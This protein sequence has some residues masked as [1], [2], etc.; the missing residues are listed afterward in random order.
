MSRCPGCDHQ[1]I[2]LVYGL[3]LPEP[4]DEELPD[5]P[6]TRV[7]MGCEM[8]GPD[9]RPPLGAWCPGCE[10]P[11]G[12]DDSVLGWDQA[13]GRPTD[14][15]PDVGDPEE[16]ASQ[17]LDAFDDETEGLQRLAVLARWRGDRLLELEAVAWLSGWGLR[18]LVDVDT[19]TCME[20]VIEL[21]GELTEGQ[22]QEVMPGARLADWHAE[23]ARWQ[24]GIGEYDESLAWW[25]SAL[26]VLPAEATGDP[27]DEIRADAAQELYEAGATDEV[28]ALAEEIFPRVSQSGAT[29]IPAK[30]ADLA[31]RIHEERAN[32][33]D[34]LTW[35]LAM[36][37]CE[38]RESD[39]RSLLPHTADA[40]ESCA[41]R[42]SGESRTR[43][44][45]ELSR[46]ARQL[47]ED[48]ERH[49]QAR[50]RLERLSTGLAGEAPSASR[51]DPSNS[52][53]S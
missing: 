52:S 53:S 24:A 14:H 47:D 28:L 23:V 9:G 41:R 39:L 51:P 26:Q 50:A 4:R 11:F 8:P 43:A 22:Q 13:W 3:V 19:T 31:A 46:V 16:V 25:R 44:S 18:D 5:E 38:L 36:A 20:R 30:T 29:A 15:I 48:D 32:W 35:R 42:L 1:R 34:A 12:L 10:T 33:A 6:S 7:V 40:L 27:A 45:R 37:R 2:D 17:W 49:R 21:L